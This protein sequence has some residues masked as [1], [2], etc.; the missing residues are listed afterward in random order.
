MTLIAGRQV[1]GA[2]ASLDALVEVVDAVGRIP[3]FTIL[4]DSGIRGAADVFKAMALGA[5]A[6]LVKRWQDTN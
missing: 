6:V 3:K 2:V 1:D 4:F 5:H